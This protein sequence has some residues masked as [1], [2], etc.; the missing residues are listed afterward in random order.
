MQDS[1][2][3]NDQK[4]GFTVYEIF[5]IFI[6]S[7]IQ[8]T[9][10][11]D[12]MVL[13]PLGAYLMPA[14]KITTTQFGLVVSAYAFSAGASGLLAAGFADKFDR[15]KLLLFFYTG[16]VVGTLF[17]AIAPDYYFLM[18]ARIFTGI[19]GGVITSISF[20]IITDLF[21]MK[22]R[23]KVMGFTQMSFAASQVLGLPIGLYLARK[24]DWH[25]PFWM[26]VGIATLVGIAMFVYM[27]PVAEHLKIKSDRNPFDHLIKTLSRSD[28]AKGFLATTFL[29]TGGYMLMPFGS[30]FSVNNLKIPLSDIELL[31]LII[32][33][34]T[35]IFGPLFGI[36]SDK[37]GKFRVFIMGS[38]L[39]FLMV[40]I[41]THL[42][43]TPFWLVAALNII[44]FAGIT[45]R[46]IS[47]SALQTA[48]PVPQDR[49]AFMSINSSVQQFSGGIASA[50]AGMIV[51]QPANNAPLEN[52]NI[53]GYAVMSSITIAI[54]LFY[55]VDL[56]VRKN[57]ARNG[58]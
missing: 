58:N 9:V 28:Y 46:M 49:G 17:C 13:A 18:G 33:L 51:I 32:G 5:I 40:A 11:L 4:N 12:F 1:K 35:I 41:Y 39:S 26:I 45:A 21:I 23:G 14:L 7:F 56:Q 48:L 3:N 55:F 31:Y 54:V 42:G 30:A 38:I 43:P 36:L 20:A 52:Y 16:F 44:L 25:A 24:L 34:P 47:S 37:I 15:K 29:A 8:F 19:F 50:I 53:L 27:K 57:L 6:I 10:V 22:V 2:N